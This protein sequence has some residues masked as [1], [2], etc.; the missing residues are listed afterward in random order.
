TKHP[1]HNLTG[2]FA[3]QKTLGLR[4]TRRTQR[5]IKNPQSCHDTSQE[6]VI[7]AYSVSIRADSWCD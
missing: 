3:R 4:M 2:F 6:F 7:L 1:A 5:G